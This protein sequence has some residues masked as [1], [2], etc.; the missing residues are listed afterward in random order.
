LAGRP[1]PTNRIVVSVSSGNA[2]NR[3]VN[4]GRGEG[5]VVGQTQVESELTCNRLFIDSRS[6]KERRLQNETKM[7]KII[8]VAFAAI[9]GLAVTSIADYPGSIARNAA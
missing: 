8:E 5:R 6:P 1:P 7:R 4:P 2:S 9:M 3:L